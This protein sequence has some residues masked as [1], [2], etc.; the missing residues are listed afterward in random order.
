MKILNSLTN[1][2][3]AKPRPGNREMKEREIKVSA[4]ERERLE[5]G[6]QT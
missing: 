6:E 5:R 1:S 2:S 3:M 4:W